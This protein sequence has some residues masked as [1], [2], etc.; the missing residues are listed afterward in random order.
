[1]SISCKKKKIPVTLILSTYPDIRINAPDT[2]LAGYRYWISAP[3]VMD[4]KIPIF[5]M[6]PDTDT[7]SVQYPNS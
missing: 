4:L 6:N 1:M 7:G 3:S 5:V 2:D